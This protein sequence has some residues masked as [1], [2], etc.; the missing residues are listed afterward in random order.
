MPDQPPAPGPAGKPYRFRRSG[1][2]AAAMLA[3]AGWL[4]G[5]AALWLVLGA[6]WWLV[7]LFAL[8]VLPALADL[9]RDTQAGLDLTDDRILWHQGSRQ[10]EARLAEIGHVRL[11]TR[12]DFSVRATLVMADG[13]RLRLPPAATPPARVLQPA[14]EARGLRTERHHFTVF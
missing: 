6:V 11:D 13:S 1:R 5:L 14:L 10:G 2:S 12:W 4:A 8:P 7:L 3:A 9:W